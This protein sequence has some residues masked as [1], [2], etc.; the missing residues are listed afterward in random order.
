MEEATS[1]ENDCPVL[2][3]SV[4]NNTP[5]IPGAWTVPPWSSLQ[6]TRPSRPTLSR[7]MLGTRQSNQLDREEAAPLPAPFFYCE[8]A[9]GPKPHRRKPRPAA[10]AKLSRR[11]A[12]M[13]RL[14]VIEGFGDT[15]PGHD[16]FSTPY[17]T[18]S[19]SGRPL[20]GNEKKKSSSSKPERDSRTPMSESWW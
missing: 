11:A 3:A 18:G 5:F 19:G 14:A 15:V 16:L 20:A 9:T 7:A 12:A 2:V 10:W 4:S 8:A 6:G 1:E 13:Q 17:S